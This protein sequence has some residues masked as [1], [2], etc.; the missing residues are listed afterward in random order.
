V[1]GLE[2]WNDERTV[3]GEQW[4]PTIAD[5]ITRSRVA[6]L[7]VSGSFLASDYIMRRELPALLEYEVRIA[8]V[9]VRPCLWDEVAILERVQWAHDPRRDGALQSAPDPEGQIVRVCKR[10]LKLVPSV[11]RDEWL[12]TPVGHGPPRR[13]TT[14][15]RAAAVMPHGTRGDLHGVPPLPPGYVV[16]NE[17]D[18][19]RALVLRA[20]DRAVG[21]TGR[22]LGL[23]GQGGIG[24]TVLAVALARDDVLRRCFPDGIFW[25]TAGESADLIAL[26]IDLLARLGATHGE[27]RSMTN[28]VRLIGRALA[29]RRCLVVVDDVWSTAAAQAFATVGP[30]G[31]VLLTTRDAGLLNDAGADVQRVDVLTR[32]AGRKL[33]A[34]LAGVTA[35][36]L[37]ASVN[38]VLDA[39]G[40]VPL[41]LALVGAAVGR[42]GRSWADVGDVLAEGTKTFLDHP[43]ANTFKAMQVGVSA[44]DEA[45]MEAYESLAV[46]P[47]DTPVPLAAVARYWSA[48]FNLTPGQSQDRLHALAVRELLS[49]GE[50]AMV[51]HDLQRDFLLLYATDLSMR[52]ADLLG[53]YRALLPSCDSPW[54]QLPQH[55]PYIWQHLFYHLHGM[56][57]ASGI[58]KTAGDMG[59]L[60]LRAF[61]SGPHAAE[62]DLRHA[63]GLSP[64]DAGVAYLLRLFTQWGHVLTGHSEL[65]DLATTLNSHAQDAPLTLDAEAL[66][67]ALPARFLVARWGMPSAPPGLMRVLEGHA[68]WVL[69]V[70]FSVDGRL[71]ASA[72]ADGSVRLWDTVNGEQTAALGGHSGWVRGVAFSP[73]G[74]VLA[75]AGGDGAIRLWDATGATQTSVMRG[76][77]GS[78]V[79][80]VAFS[81]DGRVLAS[82]GGDGLVRLWDVADGN[83][84]V[85]LDGHSGGVGGAAFS[86]DGR[87]LA[88]AGWDTSIRLWDVVGQ[89]QIAVLAGHAGGT[90]GVAFSPDGRLLASVGGDASVRLWDA[91]TGEPTATLDGHTGY[92]FGV[93]FSPDGQVIATAG[94]DGSM[95][96]WDVAGGAQMATLAGHGGAMR[97]VAFSPDGSVLAGAGDNRTVRLW[98]VVNRAPTARGEGTGGHVFGVAFSP[99]GRLLASA[100]ADKMVRLLDAGT[101]EQ[102]AVLSGHGAG[103]FGVAFSPDGGVLASAGHD[104][105]VR[106]WDVASGAQ[107]AQHTGHTL[108]VFGVAFSPDG[109][110]LASA[111]DDSLRLWD[112]ASGV[113]TASLGGH[114]GGVL[115]VAFSPDG[116]LVASAGDDRVV[117]L[118]DVAGGSLIGTLSG[119][120][121]WVRGVAFSSDG[122]VL[123]S[124]GDDP[125]VR[126]WDV[127]RRQPIGRLKGHAGWVRGVAF[128]PDGHVLA[129][130]GSDS[131]VRLWNTATAREVGRLRL[132]MGANALAWGDKGIAVAAHTNVIRLDVVTRGRSR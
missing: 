85:A 81:P 107:A 24:K 131:T 132:G 130:A 127:A 100:G 44:L 73:D 40:R 76:H 109:R 67:R 36:A 70:A 79:G 12:G 22:S 68:W 117:R 53:A 106:V 62:S 35:G 112:L 95:R 4:R 20:D 92:V 108:G 2:V 32:A 126:L 58:V 86:S 27:L 26:Q 97:S 87:V 125:L 77:T 50:D 124:C 42:G 80:G 41:A 8:C 18:R 23:Y 17:L 69:A 128:A 11:P 88:S 71:L 5:A 116:R 59:Y 46:Y 48:L 122:R 13:R 121:G 14:A 33:L 96:L 93:A 43:Y 3:T 34:S 45:L 110:V 1:R 9:L 82:A 29:E 30:R 105:V 66:D 98:N 19:L 90:G 16:R 63:A 118:W 99:D 49:L 74:A 39:T 84:I 78:G 123:A 56:G 57:D 72:G 6:L 15:S 47:Q 89:E 94:N 60:A 10:L 103:V 111:G 104:R 83:Q 91:V 37:P 120:V 102:T 119:H 115:A 101:G 38:G 113:Q 61:R 114:A 21:I 28:G 31:R 7:L 52:H 25:V 55:E 54:R 65:G 64:D 51:F 75:S 129:T